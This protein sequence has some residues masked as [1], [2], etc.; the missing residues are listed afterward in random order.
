MQ[1]RPRRQLSRL[2]KGNHSRPRGNR[3]NSRRSNRK[4]NR[5]NSQRNSRKS[6][7]SLLKKFR[8]LRPSILRIS[9][10]LRNSNLKKLNKKSFLANFQQRRLVTNLRRISSH[11]TASIP[12]ELSHCSTKMP[13]TLME[14]TTITIG[15]S[16][17]AKLQESKLTRFTQMQLN[18]KIS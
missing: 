4:S 17:K 9:L 10:L 11:K 6:C 2:K 1:S 5:K 18:S 3:R 13:A 16:K 14:T 15:K 12:L 7:P 8:K